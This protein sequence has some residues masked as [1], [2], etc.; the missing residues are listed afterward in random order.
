MA[1]GYA[2]DGLCYPD[3]ASALDAFKASM[4][5]LSG[6]LEESLTATISGNVISYTATAYDFATNN[7]RTR[8]STVSLP[9]C[10]LDKVA[11]AQIVRTTKFCVAPMVPNSANDACIDPQSIDWSAVQPSA[12]L[13]VVAMVFS[14]FFGVRAGLSA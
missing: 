8:T 11:G 14:L 2:I 10:E 12:L 1:T 3:S 9:S 4:T 13:F 5:S 7:I 6:Q